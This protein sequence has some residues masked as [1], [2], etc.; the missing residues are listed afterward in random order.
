MTENSKILIIKCCNCGRIVAAFLCIPGGEDMVGA[1]V[2][3]AANRGDSIEVTDEPVT[4][5]GCN[6]K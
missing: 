3:A 5:Q 1:S 2:M 4:L 6:C